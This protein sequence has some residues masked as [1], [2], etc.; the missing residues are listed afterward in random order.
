MAGVDEKEHKKDGDVILR[1]TELLGLL[2][3]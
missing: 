1:M 3:F 2:Y